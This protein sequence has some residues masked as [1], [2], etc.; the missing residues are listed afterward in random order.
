VSGA[1]ATITTPYLGSSS[2]IQVKVTKTLP[3]IF[4]GVLGISSVTVSASAAAKVSGGTSNSLIFAG[5]TNCGNQALTINGNNLTVTGGTHS[6][7]S[8][9][10]N[11]NNSN[12]GTTT[13]GGPNSCSYTGNGNN[14]TFGG[15]SSPTFDATNYPWPDAYPDP[16]CWKATP[17]ASQYTCWSGCTYPDT[18]LAQSGFSWN[19]NNTTLPAGV[20]CTTGQI[21]FN[22]N[23]LTG[24][25]VTFIA[26][27]FNMNSNSVTFTPTSG[28]SNLL[29]YDQ[30]T[31][32]LDINGNSFINLGTVFDPNGSILLNGNSGTISGFLE[33]KDITLNGNNTSF[34]G[35]GPPLGGG[36]A[37]VLVQ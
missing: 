18:S 15:A 36:G 32:T 22:G 37:P 7:G 35:T 10:Q 17:T 16:V 5:D 21:S 28:M 26:G 6:N 31:G 4:G 19:S 29:I 30:G 20:Y 34:I 3:S 25:G 14:T 9:F 27:S 11:S 1:T 12:F 2:T 13:Y 24:N 23:N 33:G 8:F